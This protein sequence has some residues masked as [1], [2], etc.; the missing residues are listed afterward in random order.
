MA[1]GEAEGVAIFEG[2]VAEV[3]EAVGG[4]S[5]AHLC[6]FRRWYEGSDEWVGM[7]PLGDPVL[8]SK[9]FCT[10]VNSNDNGVVLMTN[11][12]TVDLSK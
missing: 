6:L 2:C 7:L 12:G 1:A 9:V 3:A 10:T 4:R 11:F 8:K 5:G